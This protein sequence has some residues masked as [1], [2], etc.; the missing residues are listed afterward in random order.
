MARIDT[1]LDFDDTLANPQP[2]KKDFLALVQKERVLGGENVVL[3]LQSK[4]NLRVAISKH[5]D[6]Q[7]G[8]MLRDVHQSLSKTSNFTENIFDAVAGLF[9]DVAL[10]EHVMHFFQERDVP[11]V[12]G[13][14]LRQ[15]VKMN[16]AQNDLAEENAEWL[17][18]FLI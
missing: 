13:L 16:P 12:V 15:A 1:A 5:I 3:V 6:R 9:L 2:V 14:T 4:H 18:Q 10:G 7:Q 11:Q 8:R 17:G